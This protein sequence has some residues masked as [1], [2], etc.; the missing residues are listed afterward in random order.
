MAGIASSLII[1]V[2]NLIVRQA[3]P[4]GIYYAGMKNW[5][6][7]FADDV[8]P[9]FEAYVGRQLALIPDAR[10][11]GEVAYD[12]RSGEQLSVDWFVIFESCVVLV[13]VKSTRPTEQI[14]L[15]E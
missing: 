8:G 13:E 4:L 2:P 7:S 9:I 10:L 6:K 5:G 14:R 11:E 12:G 3:S 15:S 1:P